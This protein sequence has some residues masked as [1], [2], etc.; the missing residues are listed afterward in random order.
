MTDKKSAVAKEAA[1]STIST[2]CENGAAQLLEPYVVSSASNTPFPNLLENFADKDASVK[3]ASIAAVKAIVQS[4]NPWSTF[5]L[6]PALLNQVKTAG[7]WQVK[8]GCLD[9]LQQLITSAPT[10]MGEAMPDLVPVLA[11]AVWDTK[12][13]VKKAAKVTLEKAT[14]L[15]Q[16]KDVSNLV[17]YFDLC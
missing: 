2:I 15:V 13:D 7:K 16:N 3:T 8:T 5:V 12:A 1:A 11:E 9:V 10:Q 6:L 14:A 17:V 4:M